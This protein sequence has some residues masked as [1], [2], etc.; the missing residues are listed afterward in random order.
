MQTEQLHSFLG[1]VRSWLGVEYGEAARVERLTALYTTLVLG[2]AFVETIAFTMFLREFGSQNLPYAYI[3]TAVLTPL[4]AFS[5]LQLGARIS[6]QTLLISNITFLIT[7]CIMFWMSLISPAAHWVILLLPA[8]FQTQI[9]LVNLAVWPLAGRLFDVRQSK[10]LFGLVGTGTWIAN[11]VGGF[12]VAPLVALFGTDQMLLIAAIVTAFGLWQM[13]AILRADLPANSSP[14]TAPAPRAATRSATTAHTDRPMR[15]YIRLILAYVFLWWVAF[16]FLD[17]IFY[18]RASVQFQNTAQL[19]QAIGLQLAATGVL[20]LITS[21]AGIGY[22][23]RRYGLQITFLAMPVVCGIAVGALAIAGSLGQTRL[24]FWLAVFARLIN[25]AWGFSLSQSALVLSYQPLPSDR[26]HQVQTLA[27][28]I[29]QPLAIGFAG[30]I[31]LGLNTLLGLRAIELS[32]FFVGITTLLCAVIILLNRQYPQVL[33]NALA[34]REWGG[35]TTVAPADQASLEILRVALHS[36]HP[37]T[38]IYGLDMLEQADPGAVAQ[39]LPDLLHHHSAE[40]RRIAFARVER[41]RLRNAAQAVQDAIRSETEPTVR[42]AALQAL[43]SFGEPLGLAQLVDGMADP[44]QQIQRGALVGLLRYG[45]DKQR[46]I[47][48]SKLLQFATSSISTERV[49]AA[50]ILAELGTSR[51]QAQALG[52]LGDQNTEVRR[53]ALKMAAKLRDPQLWPAVLQASAAPGTIRL[54]AWALVAGG[55]TAVPVIEAALA[56][57]ALPQRQVIALINACGRI[58]GERAL[59]LLASQLSHP[60]NDTRTALLEALSASGYRAATREAVHAQ[61]R[62]EAAQAAWITAALVD[63]GDD[64]AVRPLQAALR[65]SIRRSTE[66]LCLWLSFAYD[67]P[68][69]LRARRALAQ[70]QGTQ[71][72]YALELLDAQ[73]SNDLKSLVLPIAEDLPPQERVRRLAQAFPQERQSRASRLNAI[74]SGSQARWCSAWTR[75]CALF[76]VG[77]LAAADSAPAARAALSEDNTLVRETAAWALARLDPVTSRGDHRVRS[78]IEKVLILKHVAVFQQTPDDVLADIAGLLEEREVAAGEAIF[79]KG[80][81]GDSLYIIITGKLR[82]DDGDHLLNYLGDSDVFG[83]MALLD[84]EPRIASVTA[85]EPTHVLRLDQAPFYELIVDRPEIAIGLIRVLT[86]RLRARVR[87]VTELNTRMTRL[88]DTA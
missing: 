67:A 24:L 78:T 52:L 20:A 37:A 82:V 43:A 47:A 25:V 44:D 50:Q 54:A 80:D 70:G 16:F 68:M 48:Q 29:I 83:E 36:P 57:P 9:I 79:H 35:G 13:R 59:Q 1:R 18:D 34:R 10:R 51:F 74:I 86:G 45:A 61:I 6:F 31:L 72:A 49:L 26:R 17:N 15:R 41:M 8:W 55:E 40:V 53:E 5:F 63:I 87:D 21:I 46:Q 11:I 81:L 23:L 30:L 22:V 71:H 2:V 33:S 84:T 12:V 75:A 76:A 64:Q 7:G 27:E 4:V 62:T 73:L 77:S 58:R 19:A 39:F 42:A 66:R 88:P 60:D 14:R 69:M 56:L 38:V 65:L 85:V 28:G 3:A 32:W